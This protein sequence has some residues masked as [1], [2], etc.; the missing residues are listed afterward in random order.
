M[1]KLTKIEG[2]LLTPEKIVSN[3]NGDIYHAVKSCSVGYVGFGEA[4]FSF[5]RQNAIKAWKKHLRMTLNLVVPVGRIKFVMC[6]GRAGSPTYGVI[7][8]I[9]LSKDNYCRLTIPAG[10]WNGF[11][12]LDEGI[13][14]LMNVADMQ[15]DPAESERMEVENDTINY[16]W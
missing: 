2:V 12:G 6:D 14:L 4:Y 7:Q 13:N 5:V 16:K 1:D 15:H 8:E 10:V 9:I 11:Q 3:S